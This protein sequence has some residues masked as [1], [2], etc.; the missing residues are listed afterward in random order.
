M[1][2]V[3]KLTVGRMSVNVLEARVGAANGFRCDIHGYPQVKSRWLARPQF[4]QP[5]HGQPDHADHACA[6]HHCHEREAKQRALPGLY[7]IEQTASHLFATNAELFVR[8]RTEPT[9]PMRLR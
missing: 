3:D 9:P 4:D 5:N 6:S 1:P 2:A 8:Q 7:G